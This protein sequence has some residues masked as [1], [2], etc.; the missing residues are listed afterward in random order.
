MRKSILISTTVLV[1]FLTLIDLFNAWGITRNI[2]NEGIT[3]SGYIKDENATPLPN[4]QVEIWSNKLK[5]HNIVKTTDK[6]LYN[7]Y[8]LPENNFFQVKAK[9]SSQAVFYYNHFQSV[10]TLS[11]ASLISTHDGNLENINVIINKGKK[12]IGKVSNSEGEPLSGIWVDLWSESHQCGGG[13]FSSSNG[14]YN[15]EYLPEAQDYVLTAKPHWEM[16]YLSTKISNIAISS[17]EIHLTLKDKEGFTLSGNVTLDGD[18]AVKDIVV[19]IQSVYNPDYFGWAK[20]NINGY[21]QIN[22]LPYCQDYE[23]FLK[24]PINSN[25][26][27]YHHYYHIILEKDINLNFYLTEGFAFS[28]K[29]LE[30]GSSKQISEAKVYLISESERF[31]G[32]SITDINGDYFIGNVPMASDYQFNVEADSYLKTITYNQSPKTNDIQVLEKEGSINGI[33]FYEQTGKGIPGAYI[34]VYSETNVGND[35][36]G[37]VI[38]DENGYF[39]INQLKHIDNRGNIITDYTARSVVTGYPTMTK[40]G[41]KV[42]ETLQFNLNKSSK[43]EILGNIQN[44]SGFN[45]VIDV[46]EVSLI[47]DNRFYDFKKTVM[48]NENGSFLIN[49]LQYDSKY[50]FRF[51]AFNQDG[52]YIVEYA[53]DNDKGTLEMDDSKI[54]T[55]DATIQFSFSY[56]TNNKNVRTKY[57]K[58][59][60]STNGVYL[61]DTIGKT[62]FVDKYSMLSKKTQIS[63]AWSPP[64][65]IEISGYFCILNT[66]PD[67]KINAFNSVS[68][69]LLKS[70]KITYNQLKGDDVKYFFHV[71]AVDTFGRIGPTL[72]IEFLIDNIP[73]RNI[74]IY[75]PAFTDNQTIDLFLGATGATEMYISNYSHYDD[76]QWEKYIYKK[77]WQL[78]EGFGE[79]N[80]YL[81]FKDMAGNVANVCATTIFNQYPINSPPKIS[82][83]N[84]QY[85][86]EDSSKNLIP[87]SLYTPDNSS[88]NLLVHAYSTNPNI[89]QNNNILITGNDENRTLQLTPTKD[90]FGVATIIVVC[91]DEASSSSSSTSFDITVTN[92]NDPPIISTIPNQETYKNTS[93][94]PVT[95]SVSDID[96]PATDL[97]VSAVSSNFEL[98]QSDN[99][100]IQGITE[101]RNFYI[102]P[103]AGSTGHSTITLTVKDKELAYTFTTFTFSVTDTLKIIDHFPG[104]DQTDP[105]NEVCI[106]FNKPI[107]QNSFDKND[108]MIQTPTGTI[109]LTKQPVYVS[110]TR[111][112]LQFYEQK[113][114][115]SYC[116]FIGPDIHDLSEM[117]MDQDEDGISG[118]PAEDQYQ[119]NFKIVDH[120]GPRI[121]SHY[122]FDNL[123]PPV[124][125]LEVS[126]NESI[127]SD[128]FTLDDISLSGPNGQITLI[129]LTSLS[130]K[131]FNMTFPSQTKDGQYILSI[132]PIIRDL[133]G[134]TM[135][136]DQDGYNGEAFDDKYHAH[137]MIDVNG[138][139]ITQ[140]NISD[141]QHSA[142]Q[143]I[144]IVFNELIRVPEFNNEHIII[145]N[146]DSI[147]YTAL[148]ISQID[149][150]SVRIEI[151]VQQKGGT[152]QVTIFPFITDIAGNLV[153][154]DGDHLLG[155]KIDD[156]Y[157]FEF[158][159]E[160]PDLI[161][162]DISHPTEIISGKEIEI[163]WCITNKGLGP[164]TDHWKDAIFISS[165]DVVHKDSLLGK[166][167]FDLTV[168]PGQ[169][170][171]RMM[172]VTIPDHLSGLHWI[173]VETDSDKNI[174]ENDNSNNVKLRTP[175]LWVTRRPY[176]DLQVKNLIQADTLLSGKET[177][178]SW[179]VS[180]MGTGATSVGYWHDEVILS[181]DPVYSKSDLSLKTIR[182]PDFLASGEYYLQTLDVSIPMELTP[183]T[184]Y[185][186]IKTDTRD[187]VEEFDLETNNQMVSIKPVELK[188]PTPP[189]LQVDYFL[190]PDEIFTGDTFEVTWKMT[191][192][193]EADGIYIG[194]NTFF[195]SEDSKFNGGFIDIELTHKKVFNRRDNVFP[196]NQSISGKTTLT[197]PRETPYQGLCYLLLVPNS[198][199]QQKSDMLASN[200]YDTDVGIIPF[201]LTIPDLSDLIISSIDIP[202]AAVPGQEFD[203]TW[204]I[205]NQGLGESR[206]TRWVDEIFLSKDQ[207]VNE[208][209]ILVGR[210][211]NPDFLRSFVESF[212]GA[213]YVRESIAPGETVELETSCSIPEEVTSGDYYIIINSDTTNTIY[214]SNESNNITITNDTVHVEFFEND[215]FIDSVIIP[216]NMNTGTKYA[217]EWTI[218]NQGN[219]PLFVTNWKDS[220]YLSED[221][222]FSPKDDQ[223]LSEY[224]HDEESETSNAYT[225][226]TNISI[227]VG[228]DGNAYILIEIDSNKDIFEYHG[229]NNNMY[230]STIRIDDLYADI[231]VVELVAPS[232]VVVSQAFQ[233]TWVVANSG[234]KRTDSSFYEYLYLSEDDTLSTDDDLILFDRRV[235][236][237]MAPSKQYK[238]STSMVI[239]ELNDHKE[240]V[241][242]L[243]LNVG[244]QNIYEK[245]K[246][247][248]NIGEATPINISEKIAD[249]AITYAESELKGISGRFVSVNWHVKNNG[250]TSTSQLWQD[251]VYLSEDML[252]DP[253]EDR[254][255]K[256]VHQSSPLQPNE[257]YTHSDI[258][259]S[260]LLPDRTSGSF[261]II[262]ISDVDNAIYESTFEDNNIYCIK[263]PVTIEYQPADLQVKLLDLPGES[264]AGS[265]IPIT[266]EVIN[267]GERQTDER[268]WYDTIYF[269]DDHTLEPS[270][271]IELDLF[272]HQGQLEN[273]SSYSQTA[274]I[275]LRQDFSGTYYVYVKTDS[276][277]NVYEFDKENNN[278]SSAKK[279]S[280]K[281]IRTDLSIPDVKI[282]DNLIAGES[283]SVTWLVTNT[284][285]DSTSGN[286]WED[287]IYLSFDEELDETDMILDHYRHQTILAANNSQSQTLQ[288]QIPDNITGDWFLIVKTDSSQYN[289]VFEYNAENNNTHSLF[290]TIVPPPVPDLQVIDIAIPESAWSG[291]Q[292]LVSWKDINKGNATALPKSGFWSDSVYLS[293]DPY[294][295]QSKD[296]HLGFI[297]HNGIL[298]P[299]GITLDR[300][301]P[302][303][304]PRGASGDYFI[305]IY[306]DSSQPDHVF[307][308]EFENNAFVSENSMY[309]KLTPPADLQVSEIVL[310]KN[311]LESSL[312]DWKFSIINMGELSAQ[313]SWYDTLYLSKDQHWDVY[314]HR[315]LRVFHEGEIIKGDRYTVSVNQKVPALLPDNYHVIVR[316]D[317]LDQVRETN[318]LNNTEFSDDTM[319]IVI[320]ELTEDAPIYG[321]VYDK[322]NIIFKVATSKDIDLLLKFEGTPMKCAEIFAANNRIPTRSD[323]DI[324][325]LP[326]NV[327]YQN[328]RLNSGNLSDYFFYIYGSLC[329]SEP[330]SIQVQLSSVD[331]LSIYELSVSQA[332]NTGQA[333]IK[334]IGARFLE[335]M[336]A[337]IE[338][339]TNK[340]LSH[341]IILM[342]KNDYIW[343]KFDFQDIDPG[344]YR[345]ILENPDGDTEGIPFDIISDQ[346]GKI[347][348]TLDLPSP[349][350]PGRPFVFTLNYTNV[351]FSDVASPLMEISAEKGTFLR[352]YTH[353]DFSESPLNI[354]AI[355]DE[356]EINIIPPG[357]SYSINMEFKTTSV[358]NIPFLTRIV[359]DSDKAIDWD[360]MEQTL[361]PIHLNNDQWNTIWN[362]LKTQCGATWNEYLQVLRNNALLLNERGNKTYDIKRLFEIEMDTASGSYKGAIAGYLYDRDNN[363]P[364]QQVKVYAYQ[365]Y[366]N[367]FSMATSNHNGFFVLSNLPSG[368]YII[369]AEEYIIDNF[370]ELE[371]N[372]PDTTET[373]LYVSP[374]GTITGFVA[375]GDH[376]L[377]NILI[378]IQSQTS[379]FNEFSITDQNGK[380]FI[381]GLPE[382]SYIITAISDMH[383]NESKSDIFVNQGTLVENINFYLDK[384]GT[385][386]GQVIDV[387]S[388]SPVPH[389]KVCI[390]GETKFFNHTMADENGFYSLTGIIPG[391]WKIYAKHNTYVQ[392]ETKDIEIEQNGLLQFDIHLKPGAIIIGK[393]YDE[394]G[395]PV[396]NEIV[397]AIGS[398]N[399]AAS[400][401]T[402]NMGQFELTGLSPDSYSI[403]VDIDG[404]VPLKKQVNKLW[405]GEESNYVEIHL[406]KGITA[407]GLVTDESGKP[408]A[409][410]YIYLEHIDSGLSYAL[411]G[412]ENGVYTG[413]QFIQGQY[414]FTV[415]C[416]HYISTIQLIQINTDETDTIKIQLSPGATIKGTVFLNDETTPISNTIITITKTNGSQSIAFSNENGCYSFSGLSPNTYTIN[417]MDNIN[418]F[419]SKFIEIND[420]SIYTLNIIS[421]PKSL[422]F[423]SSKKTNIDVNDSDTTSAIISFCKLNKEKM[424]DS[425]IQNN[426]LREGGL[427]TLAGTVKSED[428]EFV[429]NGDIFIY[430]S[431]NQYPIQSTTTNNAGFFI[432]SDIVPGEYLLVI[433][434]K[435][436]GEL[437]KKINIVQNMNI[438]LTLKEG[439]W[440]NDINMGYLIKGHFSKFGLPVTNAIIYIDGIKNNSIEINNTSGKIEIYLKPG[441]YD[442]YVLG[443]DFFFVYK[444][445]VN[446]HNVDIGEIEITHYYNDINDSLKDI[447][448][449]CSLVLNTLNYFNSFDSWYMKLDNDLKPKPLPEKWESVFPSSLP[450]EECTN[451]AIDISDIYLLWDEINDINNSLILLEKELNYYGQDVKGAYSNA[452][453]NLR[454]NV[455][456][457]VYNIIEGSLLSFGLLAISSEIGLGMTASFIFQSIPDIL[458]IIVIVIKKP[459]VLK[460]PI[461]KE[462][463]SKVSSFLGKVEIFK[464]RINNEKVLKGSKL[465]SNFLKYLIHLIDI[466][467]IFLIYAN[468]INEVND[469]LSKY[470]IDYNKFT[471]LYSDENDRQKSY[472]I[473]IDDYNRLLSECYKKNNQ[474]RPIPIPPP[475]DPPERIEIPSLGSYDPNDKL[476]SVGYGT[477]NH[478]HENQYIEY[479]IRFENMK[480]ATASAQL[481]TI[482]DPLSLYLDW[483]TFSLLEMQ[484]GSHTISIPE[485]RQYYSTQVDLRNE[486]NPLLVDIVADFNAKTGFAQ[487]TFSAIDPET[488]EFT[489]DM[490]AGFLPPNIHKGEGEGYV[491]FKIKPRGSLP[492]GT[493]IENVAD[494]IFDWNQ[495]ID[496]PLVFNT[497]DNH[498]P[499]SSIQQLPEYSDIYFEVEWHGQDDINDSGIS[500]F[501]IYVSTNNNEYDL[502]LNNVSTTKALFKGVAGNKY[503]FYSQS[504]DHVGNIE[505]NAEND[506]IS[507]TVLNLSSTNPTPFNGETNVS[508]RTE[509]QW[510]GSENAK[511]YELF[512]WK[513]ASEKGITPVVNQPICTYAPSKTLD[514]SS[515][516]FW[517]VATTSQYGK[518]FSPEWSFQ[519]EPFIN[520][521]PIQAANPIPL[522]QEKNISISLNLQWEGGD[523]D[524]SDQLTYEVFLDRNSPP[525]RLISSVFNNTQLAITDLEYD[526]KYFWQVIA[527]DNYGFKTTGPVWQFSTFAYYDDS[528]ADGM[529]NGWE[530]T[531]NLNPFNNDAL[532]DSD[533]DGFSNYQE[534]KYGTDPKDNRSKPMNP[535]ADSKI[536]LGE[537]IYILQKISNNL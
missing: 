362:N 533:N 329:H 64:E 374:A 14:F 505:N 333:T 376:A 427:V 152:Y 343:V 46:L 265:Q 41:L 323:Y 406:E 292:M 71:A 7:F 473:L 242:Y 227:P 303:T 248:N 85:I 59:L 485:N 470:K 21:Y 252:F 51:L 516:Y 436:Y 296:Y 182:N 272:L 435:S 288:C 185:F 417:V 239:S 259:V 381:S 420:N 480:D 23:I 81:K 373:I 45:V 82:K 151:P 121:L 445:N 217:I 113:N 280:I 510:I 402:N 206:G 62:Y 236:T 355:S 350:R 9:T 305:I 509:L 220:I 35:Y 177:T 124:D 129:S 147:S 157:T 22:L 501:N 393:L 246:K 74:Q 446:D 244:S 412:D 90:M 430:H 135:D 515:V 522:D 475:T 20:T 126:F 181:S 145:T 338:D 3:V 370:V 240:G 132:G 465:L 263:Q 513:A 108:V 349:V 363:K 50:I 4:I 525:D 114:P 345:L 438:N 97:S 298:E 311:G 88:K 24:P 332:N 388:N 308:R 390:R 294:L 315:I 526:A 330:Q 232:N 383:I 478:I 47:D 205:T 173:I 403:H 137:F 399:F 170:Y 16:P 226:S 142:V 218:R 489:Q 450:S 17:Q 83:I 256:L 2:N 529:I 178:L 301:L 335:G 358:G 84:N 241:Y 130:N 356:P 255:M 486:G 175:P 194:H 313:G 458:D 304:L 19:E 491:K 414:F 195:L 409:N 461:G 235:R 511:T 198:W 502:W 281:G 245:N 199:F 15:I 364:I 75:A 360:E 210:Y 174:D 169:S 451:S 229:E 211:K 105:V 425:R 32:E 257:M 503:S 197:I 444:L 161:V 413:S 260:V 344:T 405:Y 264:I 156:Q 138:P 536:S 168:E 141:Q 295:D 276:L 230:T 171:T 328:F 477:F 456:N 250:Q 127:A 422:S 103:E 534:Y 497:I 309:I 99:I 254:L 289:D 49:G 401:M 112:C 382:D 215:L 13:A 234:N 514:Y 306:I 490:L 111:Y 95:F 104:G 253:N 200:V 187:T 387:F 208:N 98:I 153:D 269:S 80:I 191:N 528:D 275:H 190:G 262:I 472:L 1:I 133:A 474:P 321:D 498:S 201:Q 331:S 5:Y 320:K 293:R 431:S 188:A 94:G 63:C 231:E 433:G 143:F 397:S 146:P 116:I 371:V 154:Q 61:P 128:S 535:F 271:D 507:T 212:V 496:T 324:H 392:S 66:I 411:V 512:F 136:Q 12:I 291:Q 481:I 207:A 342:K 149:P 58:K 39:Q 28:G 442:L 93:L 189:Y 37:V 454:W 368:K 183:G 380:Y 25:I 493:K 464:E 429:T 404:Y 495:P 518:Y 222:F 379:D 421:S 221:P 462:Y 452:F 455:K 267:S 162:T 258:P 439:S 204:S 336:T 203:I 506:A 238:H 274:Y 407:S 223:L 102:Q 193:G 365:Q 424:I 279:I 449:H 268:N 537:I 89:I 440:V 457:K 468:D 325:L 56:L 29:V 432:F 386:I 459:E 307:E 415:T 396:K 92:V 299:D 150:K 441:N 504:I 166:F 317:I 389:A 139:K 27:Y 115:G 225:A 524:E 499:E 316:T 216:E 476:I 359:N 202:Q 523:P 107:A 377:N 34:E 237:S 11:Q 8:K 213:N 243:F 125:Y 184:Y 357:Q 361:R 251:A 532:N 180:N 100:I 517:Q 434:K 26:A 36:N 460:Q 54:Y 354:L 30:K 284:G 521:Y 72:H 290:I 319:Q 53:G 369:E 165:G 347:Y 302:L 437:T 91:L 101:N 38:T 352:L 341:G 492:T 508:I 86:F 140:H 172:K 418:S 10:R 466:S 394:K 109:S 297:K 531:Y 334:I 69:P 340:I 326:E 144:D 186:I 395:Q 408:V 479:T 123:L 134:N 378:A 57:D 176:P 96:N 339:N 353:D 488:G 167:S 160:L 318:E 110:D 76:G 527:K 391:D 148:T 367:G 471:L 530:V 159:Q 400:S 419:P 348:S 155:E 428:G 48:V 119:A 228:M 286:Q 65:N 52:D 79:K 287:S 519:T 164:V 106:S 43:N 483:E 310:P 314:D 277:H 117:P 120:I 158:F 494:I 70:S 247:E 416:K 282:S 484:F 73:P 78:T 283:F 346:P 487:W 278:I 375:S 384:G 219:D 337:R 398:E 233:L 482:T 448:T 68:L 6:G 42:G 270:T 500:H 87:F 423:P 469:Y 520:S 312:V 327:S 122:P 351:G 60:K 443:P 366:G 131:R 44:F 273:G 31:Y 249:L 447:K 467:E 385:I 266:W 322:K 179:Q 410:A 192:T 55:T 214:E 40:T 77:P 372:E 209:D 18:D 453:D 67:H 261:Y 118:E 33:V 426:I 196:S 463:T 163:K 224:Y 300:S 285:E